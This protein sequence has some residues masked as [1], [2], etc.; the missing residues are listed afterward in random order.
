MHVYVYH[1]GEDTIA[2]FWG[3]S[4]LAATMAFAATAL[5]IALLAS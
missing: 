4:I 5:V 2:A 1:S 3:A